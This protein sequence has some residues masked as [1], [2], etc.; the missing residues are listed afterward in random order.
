[1]AFFGTIDEDMTASAYPYSIDD[2]TGV[3]TVKLSGTV[4]GQRIAATI[5][6]I[7]GDP[8]C[9]HCFDILWDGSTITE[10]MFERD[11]L[12]S[13]VRLNQQY[14]ALAQSGRDVILVARALDKAMANI[15]ASMMKPQRRQVHVCSS[16]DEVSRILGARPS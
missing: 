13:F 11:D 3:I 2:R 12:P 1:M 9:G 14:A 4:P 8:T 7:Y 15:Y 16:M 10:L 6:A 5:A